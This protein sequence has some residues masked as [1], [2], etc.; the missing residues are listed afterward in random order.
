MSKFTEEMYATAAVTDRGLVTGEPDNAFRQTWGDIHQEARRMAG[1]LAEVGIDRGVAIGILAGQPVDIAPACQATWMR[2]ASVTMLHQPTPRTDLGVWAQDTETVIDMISAKA[3]ILGAPFDAAKPLLEER[4]ITVVTVDELRSGTSIDP[5]ETAESDIAL[6]Q[7]T[8]GSTGSPKAVQITHENF[9]TNAY[10]MIN[11]IKFSIEDDVMVSW[12]PLF[13]DM[14][15]VGF[16]TVPMQVGAEVIS[17]TP[18]DFL[19]TPVLWAELMGKYGGTVTAA[20]NFAYSLLARRLAQAEDG[21]VDLSS[22]RYMWN[23]AEPVDPDTMDA[24][25]EAGARFGLNPTALAPVYGMAETTLAVSIPDPDQG[26]VLDYV[27]PDFLESM[28][29]AVP[30]N[31]PNARALATLGKMVPDLEGRIVDRDGQVLPARGVGI[32]EVRGKAVTPGYVTVDGHKPAQDDDGWL[33]TGD[34]G[35]FT[36]EGLVVVCGRVKDVIIMGGRN[37]YPTDIE[38]AAGTVA[39]VRPGNAVAIRLDAG[40]KRESFAVAVETNAFEDPEEV[41]RIER[42]VVHAVVADVGVR[43]RAVAV[44]GPGSIPKTSSGKLRRANSAALLGN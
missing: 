40:Q 29:R 5:V 30:S 9:Y 10:A 4:G 33:D 35:Y 15:M 43:P 34:V 22:V 7:L 27:D 23:G 14:G 21:A 42:E 12:L 32:I 38:R 18:M 16:L 11:R 1:G 26:Q 41:K 8:S 2:G 20:P 19:R 25:A 3:V 13:H 24:L 6:Q 36:E 39:G 44:L 17:I 37:V 31:R 28:S